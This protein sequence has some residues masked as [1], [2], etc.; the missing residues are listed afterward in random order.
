MMDEEK[1]PE[2]LPITNYQ[3]AIFRLRQ[4]EIVV[5]RLVDNTQIFISLKGNEVELNMLPK[6]GR[7]RIYGNTIDKLEAM[8]EG[9]F[10]NRV[11][12]FCCPGGEL[13]TVKTF[14]VKRFADWLVDRLRGD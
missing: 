6:V 11:E 8:I 9:L 1:E 12:L 7:T 4:G 10:E 3:Q 5:G 13:Q 2:F 14:P